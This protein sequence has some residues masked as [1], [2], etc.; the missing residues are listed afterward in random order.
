MTRR[1]ADEHLSPVGVVACVDEPL[2]PPARQPLCHGPACG[3][4]VGAA[5][6]QSVAIG[7][8]AGP[9]VPMGVRVALPKGIDRVADGTPV[10]TGQPVGQG[11][12]LELPH[13]CCVEVLPK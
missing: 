7:R 10:S 13:I 6:E 4:V 2:M 3:G 9:T 11:L 1:T 5:D 8:K 12:A